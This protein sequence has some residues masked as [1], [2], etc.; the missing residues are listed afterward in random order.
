MRLERMGFWLGVAGASYAA[1]AFAGCSSSS[2][3]GTPDTSDATAQDS[4]SDDAAPV[5]DAPSQPIV[6][7]SADTGVDAAPD[8]GVDAAIDASDAAVLDGSTDGGSDAAAA[9]IPV[10]AG[11][12][13]DAAV[14][15]GLGYTTSFTPNC[16]AC[17]GT[18]L[19][20]G[21]A[22][23]GAISRNLTPDP[24]TGLGC[25]TDAQIVTAILDGT[26]P[27]GT[28][29]CVMP[30]WSTKGMTNDQAEAIVH[31]LRTLPAV[32]KVVAASACEIPADAGVT[33]SDG[34][35][36]GDGG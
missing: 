19:S 16:S 14:A 22:V 8:G 34:G 33:A 31:Y 2:S 32:S 30:K 35:D 21:V 10:D 6:E 13:D 4:A 1:L 11:V 20:G 12:P 9:C 5:D 25:W 36:A 23:G 26:T 17:H 24:V 29:L 7:A 18:D 15:A 3:G 28:T 27:D